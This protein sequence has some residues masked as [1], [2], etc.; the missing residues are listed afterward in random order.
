[1]SGRDESDL[2]EVFV[3]QLVVDPL[4]RSLHTDTID[5]VRT[6]T[7]RMH[8]LVEQTTSNVPQLLR[9]KSGT[10]RARKCP[11]APRAPAGAT[12]VAKMR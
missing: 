10:V 8:S 12:V 3:T 7:D 6:K 5:S 2:A 9:P 1:M 4:Q 11:Q